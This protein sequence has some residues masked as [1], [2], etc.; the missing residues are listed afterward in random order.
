MQE[1]MDAPHFCSLC[2]KP[3]STRWVEVRP[4]DEPNARPLRVCNACARTRPCASCG[5]PVSPSGEEVEPGRLLCPTCVKLAVRGLERATEL[6]AWVNQTLTRQLG[7]RLDNPPRFALVT[8]PELNALA[9]QV[10]QKL[11][12]SPDVHGLFA[13]LGRDRIIAILVA[14][15]Q[16]EFVEVCAH[17]LGHA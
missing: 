6:Y 16:I 14:L 17:E 2:G 8:F 4:A 9:V 11:D 7:L 13:N 15:P 12:G 5:L 10:G 1:L 3:L